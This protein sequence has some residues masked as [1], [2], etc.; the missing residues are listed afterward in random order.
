MTIIN[1]ATPSIIPTNEKIEITF[2]KPS[3]LLGFKFLSA[4]NLSTGVNNL[5]FNFLFYL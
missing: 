4:I 1:I 2:K 3:F 5:I